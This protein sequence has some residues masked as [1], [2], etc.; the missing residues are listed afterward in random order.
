[1]KWKR[2]PN[3][4]HCFYFENS[5]VCLLGHRAQLDTIWYGHVWLKESNHRVC[6]PVNFENKE[7]CKRGLVSFA[8]FVLKWK[9]EFE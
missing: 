3:Q 7:D 5:E 9:K 8:K 6:L 4:K 2:K 1:M